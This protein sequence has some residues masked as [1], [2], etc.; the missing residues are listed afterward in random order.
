MGIGQPNFADYRYRVVD[1]LPPMY[2]HGYIMA[3]KRP[4]A[5][6][7]YDTLIYP[8]DSYC[9]LFTICS[10]LVI[11]LTLI[12]SQLLWSFEHFKSNPGVY[13][14]EGEKKLECVLK[15]DL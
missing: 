14:N 9:W 2:M 4:G 10:V 15:C 5:I 3:G 1:Y 6:A 13:I 12:F 7:S 8:F 11:F